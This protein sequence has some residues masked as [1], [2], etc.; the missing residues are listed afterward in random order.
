LPIAYFGASTG[1]A[2]AVIAAAEM[3]DSITAVVSR[4]GR[5]DLAGSAA[6]H[7]L[8]AQILMIVGEFDREVHELNKMASH[9]LRAK[10]EIEVIDGAS[11]LFEEG[12]SLDR[13]ADSAA[14]WFVE[15]FALANTNQN[16]KRVNV[17]YNR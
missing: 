12:D 8:A 11:H 4:G 16:R 1:A 10:H 5:V 9:E 2:A 3:P 17:T 15:S 13:V 14:T 6:L 7:E